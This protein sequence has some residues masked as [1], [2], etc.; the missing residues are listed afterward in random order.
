[1]MLHYPLLML[2]QNTSK[3][4]LYL[5]YQLHLFNFIIFNLTFQSVK[6]RDQEFENLLKSKKYR[7][8]FHLAV[9]LDKPQKAYEIL[10]G[11]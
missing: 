3:R 9:K 7:R 1:M 2:L 6:I 11:M 10:E 4:K 5:C 8:A